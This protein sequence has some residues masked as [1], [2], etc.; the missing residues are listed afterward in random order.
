MSN[1]SI[2]EVERNRAFELMRR[3]LRIS[4]AAQTDPLAVLCA[5]VLRRLAGF[6]CPCPQFALAKA[7]K[8]SLAQ[9]V[10]MV[11]DMEYLID[12]TIEDSL[13]CG[14]LLELSRVVLAGAED[15]P[16]WV[17]CALPS[18]VERNSCRVYLFGV[19]PDD[20]SFLPGEVRERIQY[21]GAT[22]YIEA[23]DTAKVCALLA[24]I[25]LRSVANSAWL[26]HHQ[27]EKPAVYLERFVKRLTRE[28]IA[29]DL[30]DLKI[31]A[32]L[33]A[34]NASYRNR[35]ISPGTST[36]VF[37]GRS[38]QPYGEPLWYLCDIQNGQ[39]AR[40]LLLPLQDAAMRACDQAWQIQLAIDT[41]NGLPDSYHVAIDDN[42][43][44][45]DFTFPL[46]MAARRRLIFLG[47]GRRPRKGGG[48]SFWLPASQLDE[49]KRFLEQHYWLHAALTKETQ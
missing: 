29:G 17:F 10:D 24:S 41:R 14:D 6:M 3:D 39:V 34:D 35:W 38:A 31:L 1:A 5:A 32:H 18:F 26:T 45:L 40:S 44:R 36:G 11:D 7:V 49:E 8:R 25:G 27:P 20:A 19:A 22:R 30:P 28:G 15:K 2:V 16:T 9:F 46:P 43:C 21:H 12:E 48:L 4:S 13:A 33:G 37:I 42:G 23:D 47:G